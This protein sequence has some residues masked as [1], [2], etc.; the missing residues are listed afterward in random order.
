ML[1]IDNSAMRDCAGH[2][3]KHVIHAMGRRHRRQQSLQASPLSFSNWECIGAIKSS[4]GLSA[5]VRKR[6]L[7]T[8]RQV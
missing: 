8:A 2:Q 7:R 4:A 3:Q 6:E 5:V 1:W